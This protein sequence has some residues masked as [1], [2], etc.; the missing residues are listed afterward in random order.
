MLAPVEAAPSRLPKRLSP[1]RK[2]SGSDGS[3]S[4]SISSTLIR[5][6]P[7]RLPHRAARCSEHFALALVDHR[8]AVA[9]ARDDGPAAVEDH[10][11]HQ[12]H[13]AD[14]EEDQA[15]GLDRD[16][17]DGGGHGQP[18]DE[19]DGHEG[20]GRSYVGHSRRLLDVVCCH[21][22]PARKAASN[23][24]WTHVGARQ[25]SIPTSS[26]QFATF[27]GGL[28]LYSARTAS[29]RMS[30]GSSSTSSRRCAR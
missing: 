16:A 18:K 13:Q 17:A 24:D 11:D 14:Q 30:S 9:G 23:R 7:R 4:K 8:L 22:H 21:V 19:A 10:L 6:I 29:R 3:Y 1:E 12:P 25:Y 26:S 2:P 15:D 20:D 27:A 28:P 5:F